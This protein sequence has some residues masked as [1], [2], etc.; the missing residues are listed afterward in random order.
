MSRYEQAEERV[1]KF[2][3]RTIKIIESEGKKKI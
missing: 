3:D 2:E 1:S